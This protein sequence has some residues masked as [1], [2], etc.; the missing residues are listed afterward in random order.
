MTNYIQSNY[1]VTLPNSLV[2]TV[3]PSDSGKTLLIPFQSL[4]C[5]VSLPAPQMGLRYKFMCIA[6]LGSAVTIT[7]PSGTCIGQFINLTV[8]PAVQLVVKT[9]DAACAFAGTA[10]A[11]DY[12]DINCNGVNWFVNGISSVAN[13]LA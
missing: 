8:A 5:A 11:G 4:A 9:V 13:G 6:A 12:I 2:Y 10:R 7:P 3:V 1:V